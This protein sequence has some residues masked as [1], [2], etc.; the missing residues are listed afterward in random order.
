MWIAYGHINRGW[1]RVEQ[2]HPAEGV[3]ELRQGLAA[4]EATGAKLWKGYFIGLLARALAKVG[5]LEEARAELA[6]ALGLIADT[7]EYWSAAELY[8]LEG[9]LLMAGDG[10]RTRAAPQAED[11]FRRALTCAREQQAK[12]WELRV[13]TSLGRFKGAFREPEDAHRVLKAAYDSFS[14]GRETADLREA[15]SVLSDVGAQV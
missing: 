1:A 6:Q 7:G 10:S 8:R 2:G 13:L 5:R 11:C 14:E 9:E 15:E 12:S 4:Y 3:E